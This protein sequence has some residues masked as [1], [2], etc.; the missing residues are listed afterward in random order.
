VPLFGEVWAR[1]LNSASNRDVSDDFG[2]KRVPTKADGSIDHKAAVEMMRNAGLIVGAA[3]EKTARDDEVDSLRELLVEAARN[4]LSNIDLGVIKKRFVDLGIATTSAR[5]DAELARA[6][7]SATDALVEFTKNINELTGRPLVP[8]V[9]SADINARTVEG[10]ARAR[11]V[12]ERGFDSLIPPAEEV[13][14]EKPGWFTRL[15]GGDLETPVPA[16]TV[17]QASLPVVP[18]V[19]QALLPAGQAVPQA[20]LPAGPS[21]SVMTEAMLRNLASRRGIPL[22]DAREEMLALGIRIQTVP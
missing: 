3:G 16:S 22:D 12:Q 14:P 6:Q 20:S 11:S 13:V 19:P 9:T 4:P 15:F 8:L 10:V 1:V 2:T 18:T 21:G 17:P 5:W 7:R